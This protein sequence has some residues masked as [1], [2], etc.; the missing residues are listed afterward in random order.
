MGT[1][2]KASYLRK[3]ILPRQ[4]FTPLEAVAFCPILKEKSGMVLVHSTT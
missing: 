3:N 1:G 2:A 4:G